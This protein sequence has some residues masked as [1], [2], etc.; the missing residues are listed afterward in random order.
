MEKIKEAF[1]GKSKEERVTERETGHT[2]ASMTPAHPAGATGTYGERGAYGAGGTE[3]TG[4]AAGGPAYGTAVRVVW[5]AASGDRRRFARL[6]ASWHSRASP[7]QLTQTPNKLLAPSPS[8]SPFRPPATPRAAPARPRLRRAWAPWR[9]RWCSRWVGG[10]GG[11]FQ[12][13]V[14][15]KVARQPHSSACQRTASTSV[16]LRQSRS[17]PTTLPTPLPHCRPPGPR[18]WPRA[19][20]PSARRVGWAG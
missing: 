9:C 19:R 13:A 10:V 14:G 16:P 11:P 5:G 3:Y 18:A 1:T 2:A 4:G 7:H 8:S 20:P 6:I 17:A 12:G 15:E